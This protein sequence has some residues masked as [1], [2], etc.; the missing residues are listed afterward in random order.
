MTQ[1]FL[2][3]GSNIDREHNLASGLT[4]LAR[5]FGAMQLSP[6]YE[7]VAVGFVGEPFLNMV[8]QLQTGLPVGQLVD[9]LHRIEAGHGRV[10][11]EKKCA[12]RTLDIDVLTYG[13]V[14]GVVDG[15]TLPRD[16]IYRYAFVLKPL[17]DLAGS[18]MVPGKAL[19]FD[20]L[21]QGLDFEAQQLWQVPFDW[22]PPS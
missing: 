18:Q 19:S 1:V 10:R 3:L 16:E 4:C 13:D 15:V 20:Q 7:S 2:S 21:L 8:V 12:S 5:Q 6:V 14:A 22:Q 17:C 9:R 11:G